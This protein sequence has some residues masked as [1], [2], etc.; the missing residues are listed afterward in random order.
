[1]MGRRPNIPAPGKAGS[2]SLFAFEHCRPG[3]PE[4][5]CSTET[6]PSIRVL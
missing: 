6:K 4:P 2:A 5:G 3:L 1:M